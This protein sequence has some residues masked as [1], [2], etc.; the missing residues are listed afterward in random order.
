MITQGSLRSGPCVVFAEDY[1]RFAEKSCGGGKIVVTL[2][3]DSG[4]KVSFFIHQMDFVLVNKIR[5]VF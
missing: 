3:R 4:Y 5:L 2:Q 1:G